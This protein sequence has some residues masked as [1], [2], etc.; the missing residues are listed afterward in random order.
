MYKKQYLIY[1]V[2]QRMARI[3]FRVFTGNY[4][5]PSELKTIFPAKAI[6]NVNI[7]LPFVGPLSIY[8]FVCQE[9]CKLSYQQRHKNT[10]NSTS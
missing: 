6:I 4:R 1:F 3:L 5:F 10:I 8:Q 7:V 9:D 2:D